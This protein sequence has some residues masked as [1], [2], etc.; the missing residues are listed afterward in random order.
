[1]MQEQKDTLDD[2]LGGL[3]RDVAPSRELWSGIARGLE[4]RP[5]RFVPFALAASVCTVCAA[6]ALVFAVMHGRTVVPVATLSVAAQV[7]SFDEPRDP[8][9][10]AARME[11]EKT[12]N[13]R[14]A[15]MDATTRGKIEASLTVIRQAHE[16]MRKALATQPSDPVLEQ[17]LEST[18]ND[19][20]ELY[21]DV[22]RNTQ[23]AIVRSRT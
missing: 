16:E 2:L 8:A 22:V 23:P 6:A 9:Y 19:E 4:R 5:H 1:M 18:W 12:F 17:L 7:P 13:E 15:M 11:L 20:F 10:R 14:L 3:P 21:D